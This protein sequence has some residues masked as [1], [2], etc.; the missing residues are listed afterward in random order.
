MRMRTIGLSLLLIALTTSVKAEDYL[1]S[2]PPRGKVADEQAR[3]KPIA[4]F[5]TAKTGHT[6]RYQRESAW[7]TYQFNMLNNNYDLIF[8]GPHFVSWR[9]KERGHIPLLKL[10]VEHIWVVVVGKDSKLQTLDDLVAHSFCG[11][12][13]PN[14]ATLTLLSHYP[15][16]LREP[17]LKRTL[18][19]K[20]IYEGVVAG[21]CDAG[22]VPLAGLKKFDPQRE[23]V[24]V[25]HQ[26]HPFPNQAFTAGPRIPRELAKQ[27]VELLQSPEGQEATQNLRDR[28]TAGKQLVEAT[29]SE[30]AG[31]SDIL[32]NSYGYGSKFGDTYSTHL[33]NLAEEMG[34]ED[35]TKKSNKP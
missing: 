6:F 19:W 17:I 8:D 4:E 30:Y 22:V 21:E 3:Y 25:I 10:P 26:H 15:N 11:H 1:F 12:P 28:Y 16:P 2:A 5:L 31:I 9:I 35:T 23:R 29:A 33:Q 34:K 13:T 7:L 20:H 32:T 18:G 27:I 14:F 24:K